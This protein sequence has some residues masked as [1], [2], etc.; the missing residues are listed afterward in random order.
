MHRHRHQRLPGKRAGEA[1]VLKTLRMADGLSLVPDRAWN[2]AARFRSG[3]LLRGNGDALFIGTADASPGPYHL[4]LSRADFQRLHAWPDAGLVNSRA[5][6]LE[7][8]D[9]A[10]DASGAERYRTTVSTLNRD[11]AKWAEERLADFLLAGNRKTGFGFD[12]SSVLVNESGIFNPESLFEESRRHELLHWLIGRGAGATPAG[13]D[14]IVGLLAIL[15]HCTGL[16][17]QVA[18]LVRIPGQTGL[19]SEA[20]YKAAL[21]GRFDHGISRLTGAAADRDEALFQVWMERVQSH[22]HS[23]GIDLL[24]GMHMALKAILL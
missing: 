5:G 15:P 4:L 11:A 17:S 14:F 7:R 13:D 22:G 19:V 23:S 20:Y 24:C 8:E 10:I 16:H 6:R 18:D 2:I 9:M 12:V 21:A 3:I 1:G